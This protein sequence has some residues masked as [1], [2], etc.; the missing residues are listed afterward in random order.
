MEEIVSKKGILTGAIIIATLLGGAWAGIQIYDYYFANDTQIEVRAEE[1]K[2]ILPLPFLQDLRKQ[3]TK[4]H[5]LDLTDVIPSE[6]KD[7]I[8]AAN[9]I[10]EYLNKDKATQNNVDFEPESNG[11]YFQITIENIGTKEV[12]EL[13]LDAP[14]IG[15]PYHGYYE[16]PGS[17]PFVSGT[18]SRTIFL[19]NLRPSNSLKVRIW[20]DY[21]EFN[22]KFEGIKVTSPNAVYDAV[23]PAKIYGLWG[24]IFD[25]FRFFGPVLWLFIATSVLVATIPLAAFYGP[26]WLRGFYLKI[27]LLTHI[28]RVS[29]RNNSEREVIDSTVENVALLKRKPRSRTK[30]K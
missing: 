12:P 16:I 18:F 27:G 8:E 7:K 25:I 17:D 22:P 1:S 30:E 28:D 5:L 29:S 11:E 21:S 14:F 15:P 23:F 20:S 6:V 19:G 2:F 3:R 26:S 9:R 10:S 13:R 24:S 4:I